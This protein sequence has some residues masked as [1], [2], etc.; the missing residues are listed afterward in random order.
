MDVSKEI[1]SISQGFNPHPEELSLKVCE[2]ES[3]IEIDSSPYF[4]SQS[5]VYPDLKL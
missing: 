3:P 4:G 5:K 2:G 1:F